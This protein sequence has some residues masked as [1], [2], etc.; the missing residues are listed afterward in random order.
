M[1]SH[2]LNEK[3]AIQFIALHQH[4]RDDFI[5]RFADKIIADPVL[6][7][8]VVNNAHLDVEKIAELAE[9]YLIR[10]TS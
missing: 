10:Y 8:L 5:R 9:E 3:D 6:Y 4:Q 2:D 7:H 1:Q